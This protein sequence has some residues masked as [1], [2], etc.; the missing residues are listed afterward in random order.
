MRSNDN[1]KFLLFVILPSTDKNWLHYKV[2]VIFL[3]TSLIQIYWLNVSILFF[4]SY[5]N[6]TFPGS[7]EG[8]VSFFCRWSGGGVV[9]WPYHV[10]C[11]GVSWVLQVNVF[12]GYQMAWLRLTQPPISSM[13]LYF[14]Y[15]I[16]VLNI[17][18]VLYIETTEGKL[19]TCPF[20]AVLRYIYR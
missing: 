19:K 8:K 2:K 18:S 4:F 17:H 1:D 11:L 20:W 12:N 6:K 15:V 7:G 10:A 9:W 14:A 3:F 5:K 16:L 13:V